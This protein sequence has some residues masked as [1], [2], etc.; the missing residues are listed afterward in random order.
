ML[1]L[2]DEYDSVRPGN[3]II[4]STFFSTVDFE[5]IGRNAKYIYRRRARVWW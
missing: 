1:G 2:S 4:C 5:D 3:H